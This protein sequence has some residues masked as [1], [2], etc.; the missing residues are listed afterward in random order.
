MYQGRSE[1][2]PIGLVEIDDFPP[3]SEAAPW[4]PSARYRPETVELYFENG[5][6]D[7][8][9][10]GGDWSLAAALSHH[11][12]HLQAGTPGFIVLVRGS[13]AHKDFISKYRIVK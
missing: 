5:D 7:L 10:V 6:A 8:V 13:K 2:C 12:F 3:P 9:A 1:V 11:T 4:D